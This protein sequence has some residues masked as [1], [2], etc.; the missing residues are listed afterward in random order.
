MS[1]LLVGVQPG[2]PLTIAGAT[3]LCLVTAAVGCL[4]PTLE[5]ARVDPLLVIR[6][7]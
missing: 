6:A 3:F 2:D 1:G 5:A 7:E 4:R